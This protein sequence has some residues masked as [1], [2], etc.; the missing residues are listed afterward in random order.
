M[1]SVVVS[2]SSAL[3]RVEAAKRRQVAARQR[4]VRLDRTR[5]ARIAKLHSA[6][7]WAFA[8]GDG[9]TLGAN[10]ERLKAYDIVVVDGETTSAEQVAQ[11]HASGCSVLA[12]V[13]VGTIESYRSWYPRVAPYRLDLWGDWGE[14]YADV[15][16]AGYRTTLLAETSTML[17]K[18]ADGLFLDNVDMV[19]VH[20]ERST[21]MT[22]LVTALSAQTRQ[23][24]R[25]LATQ[26]GYE[27]V[28]PMRSAF[29][30]WNREDVT[31]TYDFEAER[32]LR[33]P[34]ADRDG[35][36]RELGA[37]KGAG[38]VTMATDY[39]TAEDTATETLARQNAASV[40]ALSFVS[41]ILLTRISTLP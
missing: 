32:Y 35:A 40:G 37:M 5:L 29:S 9:A 4:F 33:T 11:L 18:G 17:G 36:L 22:E 28:W 21:G 41:D 14:W 25:V 24:G 7:S 15:N 16:A 3:A 34:A 13:S 27:V 23:S 38:L 30:A 19:D 10:F 8:I 1:A 2:P 26:N 39:T 12:Y 31:S 20:P 6:G